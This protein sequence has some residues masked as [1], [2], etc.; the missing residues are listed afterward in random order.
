MFSKIIVDN[1]TAFNH[2]EFDLI[3]NRTDKKAK[4]LAIIYGEN[5]IGKTC[6][7]K[8]FYFLKLSYDSLIATEDLSKLFGN[9]KSEDQS[10]LEKSLMLFIGNAFNEYRVSGYLKK[11]YKINASED[12]KLSYEL[13][14]NKKRY[15]YSM[16]FNRKSII[17]EKLLFDGEIVYSCSPSKVDLSPNHFLKDELKEKCKSGFDMYFGEKHTLLSWFNFLR[18]NVSN[19][20][21]KSG[22]SKEFL[23]FLDY[24]NSLIVVTKDDETMI[25]QLSIVNYSTSFLSPISSGDYNE[26]KHTKLKMTEMALSMFFSSLYSNIQRVEYSIETKE[27][28]KQDYH[29]FFVEK[30]NN[31]TIMIPFEME[32]TGTRKMATLFT[33]LYEL[34]KSKKTIVVDEIDNGINDILLKSIFES[35]DNS[36]S[37]QFIVTTHNTLLLRNSIKKNIYLLDRDN[38]D[39]VVS[40][41]LDEFGRKIQSGTDIIGQYLKGLYGGVPQSGAF[42]MKYISEAMETYEQK[43]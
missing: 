7:I 16:V 11:Y 36:I 13:I 26:K 31:E 1:F 32:S 28:G 29:L 15:V 27:T 12:M 34:V 14:I 18:R 39:S 8:S 42:S 2:F 41:S 19:S 3:E 30:K 6:L 20:F 23:L 22:V 21:F 33:S 5:G 25:S 38:N 4:K 17:Q 40:Y 9:A 37:G 10:G 24:L 35:L 43:H